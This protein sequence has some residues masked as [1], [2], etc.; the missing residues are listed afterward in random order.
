MIVCGPVGFNV[1][2]RIEI[3]HCGRR[4]GV[5]SSQI[6][7]PTSTIV[8][9][10]SMKCCSPIGLTLM[11]FLSLSTLIDMRVAVSVA[12]RYWIISADVT[13]IC[14]PVRPSSA[15]NETM[16]GLDSKSTFPSGNDLNLHRR[17]R[18]GQCGLMTPNPVSEGGREGGSHRHDTNFALAGFDDAGAVGP[19]ES[20]PRALQ[21]LLDSNHVVLG[22]PLRDAHHQCHLSLDGLLNGAGCKGG[23]HVDDRRSGP[24]TRK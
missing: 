15:S 23:G 19:D 17:P 10:E 3:P 13:S 9:L 2:C 1:N 6:F 21:H 5:G 16:T 8:Q 12:A 24:C 14:S 20:S 11:S 22:D 18:R 7:P 4:H